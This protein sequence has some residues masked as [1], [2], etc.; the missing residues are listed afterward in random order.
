MDAAKNDKDIYGLRYAEFVV[1]LVKAVQE[2]SGENNEMKSEIANLRSEIDQLKGMI[3]SNNR[4]AASDE[5]SVLSGASL[6]QNIPNPFNHTTTINYT[7]PQTYSSAKI[8]VVDKTG[9][10]LRQVSISG[11]DR[12]SIT[13]DASTLAAGAYSYS[14]FVDGKLVETKHM[15]LS[16]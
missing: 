9:K 16:K 6:Q 12:G 2:L 14:L 4:N 15:V 1:P 7:L 13:I 10:A 11:N 5:L 8:A 3:I